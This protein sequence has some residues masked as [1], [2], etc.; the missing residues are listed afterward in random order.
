MSKMS[1]IFRIKFDTFIYFCRLEHHNR[2]LYLFLFAAI[3]G[4]NLYLNEVAKMTGDRSGTSPRPCNICI[5][6]A[7]LLA[8]SINSA[9]SLAPNVTSISW[10]AK[11]VELFDLSLSLA[12]ITAKF[13][14][15][16]YY[17]FECPGIP[18]DTTLN[19]T[20]YIPCCTGSN[21]TNCFSKSGPSRICLDETTSSIQDRIY[22]NTST[23]EFQ[24]AN[25]ESCHSV[26]MGL[27]AVYGKY[28]SR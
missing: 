25:P 22:A 10:V 9:S 20:K 16:I 19:Q 13:D 8:A 5:L 21:T 2:R 17:Q 28:N 27:S 26:A 14:Q 15:D 12:V 1:A 23:I 7:I 11:Q 24:V 18:S 4:N 3:K 6:L